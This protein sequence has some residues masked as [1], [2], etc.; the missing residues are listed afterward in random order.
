MSCKDGRQLL[1]IPRA[2]KRHAGLYECSATNVLGSITSSCTVAV[3]RTPGKLAPPEVPQTYCDTA[4]VLWKPGDSRAPCTYTLER[5]VDGE[6]VWHP[7]SSGIPDCYYNV[8]QLPVGVTVRFRVA[9]SNRAGQ[10]PFSNPSEKV[11]IR[12]TQDS[13]AQSAAA[14]RDAPVTS[15]PTRAP[16]PD[17]PTSLVPTPAL[18]PQVSQASTLSPSTSSMSAN[19]ALSSLK[20]VGPPPATPPRKHRGLLATQQAEPSPPSILVTPSEPKSFVPD[21][22][23]LTPTSSPQGVKPAPSSSS[24]YMVTSFV[25]APPDPQPPAPEPPPEPT[26]VTV[27]SLSPAKEVVSSPTP[28]STTLRQGPPQKPYTFLEEK[29][30]GRFGVVRSCRENATGRTF[31]AKIVPYAAEGKRRVLQEYE[32]LRTLH[33]ERPDRKSV[34]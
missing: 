17:S 20:A 10:G 14:P 9:C 6:S 23:T 24:L 34:V 31:V 2:S 25:S 32:V 8:T 5:R 15:G 13:P 29:A 19:Q 26:K 12:G 30:R 1:S 21:T 27:R 16:P 33:H 28:E 7:V 11:F 4:L 22:G 3:A 18:A